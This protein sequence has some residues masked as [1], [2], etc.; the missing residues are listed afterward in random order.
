MSRGYLCIAQNSDGVDYLRMAYLQALSCKLTQSS[1][2][3]FSVIVDK[4]TADHVIR[5]V[6]LL[7]LKLT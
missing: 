4:E 2:R 6:A 3:N 5:G 7:T 1:V